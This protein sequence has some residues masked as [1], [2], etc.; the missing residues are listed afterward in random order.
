MKLLAR[1]AAFSL[2]ASFA[3]YAAPQTP[4]PKAVFAAKTV[5]IVNDTKTSEVTEGA[6]EQLKRWGHFAVVDDPESADIVLRFDHKNERDG[7]NT[8][9]TDDKGN[10][11]EWG[12]TMT[13][14][15]E[16]HMH[17]YLKGAD[18]PFYSNKSSDGKKKGGQACVSSFED[19]WLAER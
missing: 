19:A 3:F 1:P 13:F 2:I 5:A 4:L 17:A 18:A 7:K 14:A 6:M 11:N 16:T 9:K 12:Y 8:Q 15:S 10:V